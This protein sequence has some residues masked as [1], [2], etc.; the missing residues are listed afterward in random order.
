LVVK[1]KYAGK[2]GLCP[3][4]RARVHVPVPDVSDDE[5]VNLLGPLEPRTTEPHDEG[6]VH[7]VDAHEEGH[8]ESGV[9]LNGSSIVRHEK[10]CPNCKEAVPIWYASCPHCGIYFSILPGDNELVS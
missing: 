8:R 5:I 7:Q 3:H 2:S 4:C 9:S 10:R 6:F 1:D